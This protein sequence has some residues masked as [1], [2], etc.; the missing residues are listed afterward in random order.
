M[1]K[2]IV[3]LASIQKRSESA[4]TWLDL[5]HI[6][7]VEATSEDPDFPIE[8]AFV[9]S[10]RGWRASAKG[11]QQIRII[12][13]EPVSIQRIHLRFEE[14]EVERTQEFAIRWAGV[15]GGP[16]KEVVRQQWTFSPAGST[17][18]VED[19]NVH[20]DGVSVLELTIRPDLTRGDVSATLAEWRIA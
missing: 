11:K 14:A 2:R 9:S 19:Y 7:T 17:S 16:E 10:G 20:L 15:E 6:A 1:R 13:D 3:G 8:S 12:F 5:E 18:E 4:G